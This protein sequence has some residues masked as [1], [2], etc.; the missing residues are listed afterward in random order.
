MK[1]GVTRT[2]DAMRIHW[3]F[4]AATEGVLLHDDT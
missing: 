2:D 3:H 4:S 1:A